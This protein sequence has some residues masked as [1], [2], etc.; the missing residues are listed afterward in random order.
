VN[1][2]L[3]P[4][5]RE[6]GSA[7]GGIGAAVLWALLNLLGAT[8]GALT[9]R[10]LIQLAAVAATILLWRRLEEPGETLRWTMAFFIA[11]S[12]I[13]AFQ[14]ASFAMRWW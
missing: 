6:T 8:H 2:G 1:D 11:F 13:A 10:L 9:A 5:R 12:L 7:A 3:G 4:I 14:V